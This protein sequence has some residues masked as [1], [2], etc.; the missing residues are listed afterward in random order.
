MSLR[1]TSE[2]SDVR[3]LQVWDVRRQYIIPLIS[4]VAVREKSGISIPLCGLEFLPCVSAVFATVTRFGL[5]EPGGLGI[6][7]V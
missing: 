3:A 5:R 2:I 4:R 7:D 6:G 1:H